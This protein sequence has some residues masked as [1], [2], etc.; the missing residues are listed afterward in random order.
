[1]ENSTDRIKA[2]NEICIVLRVVASL[3]II[4]ND[5]KEATLAG[6]LEED[7]VERIALLRRGHLN[8]TEII[9]NSVL[10]SYGVRENFQHFKLKFCHK[11]FQEFFTAWYLI[12]LLDTG[13]SDNASLY[14][15]KYPEGV[16]QFYT[17][18]L[19]RRKVS[20]PPRI[21]SIFAEEANIKHTESLMHLLKDELN[22]LSSRE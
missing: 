17:D 19:K 2:F 12:E 22:S 7:Q 15:L 11:S 9:L 16:V 3:M 20:E 21:L 14:C 18:F 6:H 1:L 8:I 5:R 4:P 10:V 13:I